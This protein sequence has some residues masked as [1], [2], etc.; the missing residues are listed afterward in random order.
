MNYYEKPRESVFSV[1]V[2]K[3]GNAVFKTTDCTDIDHSKNWNDPK[4]KTP[5]GKVEFFVDLSDIDDGDIGNSMSIKLP[6]EYIL[7]FG[8]SAGFIALED[9]LGK[10]LIYLEYARPKEVE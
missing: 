7:E 1:A 10:T 6:N 9:Q 4:Y 3:H 5:N 2:G 8:M